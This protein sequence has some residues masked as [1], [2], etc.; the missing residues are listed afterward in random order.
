M[1]DK[2]TFAGLRDYTMLLLTLDTGIRP[3]E[4]LSLQ[5]DDIN[6]RALD[7]HTF[8]CSRNQKRPACILVGR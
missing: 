1:P 6:L 2:T 5:V 7:F 8:L 4:A 3:K